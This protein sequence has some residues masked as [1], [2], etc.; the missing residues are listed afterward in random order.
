MIVALI[1]GQTTPDAKPSE[2]PISTPA[3][4]TPEADDDQAEEEPEPTAPTPAEAH[5]LTVSLV[6]GGTS[7]L[8]TQ[9]AADLAASHPGWQP[10][11]KAVRALLAGAGITVRAGVRTPD[12]NGPGVH[13]QDVPPLPSSSDSAPSSGVV[14]NVGPGQS[15]NA[16]ANNTGEDPAREGFALRA[17]PDNPARTIVVH[18]ADVA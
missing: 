17:D 12:G 10:S 6:A 2:V 14:A 5:A 18:S 1:A 13:H 15:A 7:V 16:N 8:L 4:D 11:T 9:L 3:D